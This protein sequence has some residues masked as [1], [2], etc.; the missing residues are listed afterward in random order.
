MII[1]I[2]GL[3]GSGKDLCGSLIQYYTSEC[4]QPNSQHPRSFEEFL[5]NRGDQYSHWYYSDWEI[6]KFGYKLK[7]IAS[8]VLGVPVEKFEDQDFKKTELGKEW[9]KRKI[10]WSDGWDKVE[11]MFSSD[12]NTSELKDDV[13]RNAYI[14]EDTIVKLTVREFL[15]KLG[16]E[17][18]R[19]QIHQDFW[20]N[21]LMSE[22]KGVQWGGRSVKD[23]N[24][25]PYDYETYWDFPKWIIT[26]LRFPN[27]Y[28]SI[29]DKG[30]ICIKINRPGL[31]KSNHSSET[32][33]DNHEF[34]FVIDNNGDLEHL[35]LE[36]KKFLSHYQII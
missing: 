5:K 36:V 29:K 32:S 14:Y 8:L 35:S 23:K 25:I 7:Q 15:Q 18:C 10:S 12:F 34:D 27:E 21:A 11:N 1:G 2:N 22:Y 3:I 26:D 6:K 17:A 20:V 4:S 9:N 33:L 13:G 19:D 16:T 31:T 28:K 30:G 24:G